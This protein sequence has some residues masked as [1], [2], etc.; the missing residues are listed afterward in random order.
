MDTD[1]FSLS[2]QQMMA[3]RLDDMMMGSVDGM[4]SHA[5]LENKNMNFPMKV[6]HSLFLFFSLLFLFFSSLFF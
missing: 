3:P 1:N 2:M 4:T 6:C 5:V